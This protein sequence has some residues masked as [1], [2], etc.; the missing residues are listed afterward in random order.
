MKTDKF[1]NQILEPGDLTVTPV[2]KVLKNSSFLVTGTKI[3][4]KHVRYLTIYKPKKNMIVIGGSHMGQYEYLNVP[5][6]TYSNVITEVIHDDNDDKHPVRIEYFVEVYDG[7]KFLSDYE[8]TLLDAGPLPTELDYAVKEL[9][10][11]YEK[12]LI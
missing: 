7:K 1:G 2:D 5:D 12:N 6:Y 9:I 8:I 4:L 10:S 11:N 3:E